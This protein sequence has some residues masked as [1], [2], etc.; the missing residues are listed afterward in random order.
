MLLRGNGR[1][2]GKF[3]LQAQP[4]TVA[5]TQHIPS[6]PPPPSLPRVQDQTKFLVL[7]LVSFVAGAGTSIL[8]F[9]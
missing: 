9:P 6:P 5:T 2:E 7:A 1:K 8:V 3:K 4:T